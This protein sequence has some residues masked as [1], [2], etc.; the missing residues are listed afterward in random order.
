VAHYAYPPSTPIEW[1]GLAAAEVRKLRITIIGE[2]RI[3]IRTQL[4]A[5]R[6]ADLVKDNLEIARSAS[7]RQ[8]LPST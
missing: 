7:P 2:I 1:P 8:A 3:D 4:T 5:H 6:F